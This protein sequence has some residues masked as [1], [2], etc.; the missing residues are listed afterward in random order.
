[1]TA[2]T[3]ALSTHDP[4]LTDRVLRSFERTASPRLREIVER[5][6]AH[7]HAFSSEVGLTEPEWAQAIDFVT[8]LGQISDD[9]RQETILLSDVLGLSMLTIGIN[10]PHV[11]GVTD[12]TVFGPFFVADSPGFALGDDIS[13]GAQGQP[14]SYSGSVRSVHGEPIAGARMEIWHSDEDGNYDVQYAALDGPQG[15][16]HLF[17][18]ADGCYTF[19]SVLPEPYPIPM[20]GPVGDLLRATGR[21]A[22]RPAHVHFMITAEGYTDLITHVFRS[23]DPYLGTDAVFGEKDSLVRNFSSDGG[24]PATF[25]MSYDFVLD[26]RS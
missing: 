19:R 24:L 21:S 10:H 20:D 2:P 26:D 3:S 14:C 18:D 16:G 12:A 4:V 15:R 22:M 17:T 8:R 11:D 13:G 25:S 5:L 6:V 7:L 1:M 9:K 23:G